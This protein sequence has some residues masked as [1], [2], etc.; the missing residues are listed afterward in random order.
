MLLFS[1]IFSIIALLLVA[2]VRTFTLDVDS[3]LHLGKWEN[4]TTISLQL[5][6]QQRQNLL[7]NFK[8]AIRIPTVSFTETHVNTS[9]LQEFDGLLRSVF[10]K[11]F[12]SSL[13]R[14]EVV[15]NYSHLF[16]IA[17][18]DADLEPYMLLAHIDVVPANEAD[19]WDAPP[20]SAQEINGFIYGRGTIDNKQSVMVQ[21]INTSSFFT[22]TDTHLISFC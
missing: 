4:T 14:H 3:G 19:G 5:R 6:T 17:G 21:S 2:T 1:V 16:T 9:A 7:A 20:F 13:V 18:T 15:G 22:K 11:V 10:P 12:S 8:A